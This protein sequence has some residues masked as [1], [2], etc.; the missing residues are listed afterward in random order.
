MRVS[1]H[2]QFPEQAEV[3][4]KRKAS[5]SAKFAPDLFGT[6][7]TA[8]VE[9]RTENCLFNPDKEDVPEDNGEYDNEEQ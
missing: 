7:Q 9:A 1:D 3:I 8:S 6:S 2:L 4:R 5:L